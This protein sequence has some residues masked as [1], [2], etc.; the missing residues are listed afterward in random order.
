[1]K[2]QLDEHKQLATE[3]SS[4]FAEHEALLTDLEGL[5]KLQRT[6]Q[7][8]VVQIEAK[9]AEKFPQVKIIE[10]AF[11]PRKPFRPDYS[12]NAMIAL[13]GSILLGLF[14]VWVVDYLTRKEEQNAAIS[15]SG[16]NLYAGTSPSLINGYPQANKQLSPSSPQSLEQQKIPA[17]ES[18][19][20]RELKVKELTTLLETADVKT[21]QLVTLLL[22]GLSLNEISRLDKAH[23]DLAADIIHIS[24]DDPRTIP[25]SPTLKALF[26]QTEP[27]P[28]WSKNQ[29]ITP[30]MLEA[31]LIYAAA[32][33][34]FPETPGI[35]VES[36]THT[37]IVYLVKQGIRLAEL[38]LIIGD[39]DPATLAKYSRYSPA[40]NHGNVA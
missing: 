37:Y 13:V 7:E 30:K 26:E 24:G 17:L 16:L 8:R 1:M 35:N 3:F 2:Q 21:R 10:R 18:G 28:A 22:S 9:Q 25:L 14:S 11:Q 40:E 36:I 6:T 23:I 27:C 20:P 12:R 15:I 34:G 39:T 31:M 5:E 32:D 4:K 38:E 29:N 19:L 33:A